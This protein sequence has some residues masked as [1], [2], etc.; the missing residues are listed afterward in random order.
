METL[1]F[2]P[3]F[4]RVLA[5]LRHWAEWFVWVGFS[6]ARAHNPTLFMWELELPC[7]VLHNFNRRGVH[8]LFLLLLGSLSRAAL[9]SWGFR[10]LTCLLPAKSLVLYQMKGMCKP[11]RSEHLW[12]LGVN[13]LWAVLF[14]DV[15]TFLHWRVRHELWL[16]SLDWRPAWHHFWNN[17]FLYRAEIGVPTSRRDSLCLEFMLCCGFSLFQLSLRDLM[18][19]RVKRSLHLAK[20]VWDVF[21]MLW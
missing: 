13:Y 15:L 3:H 20:L 12:L 21:W 7:C 18:S 17:F 2:G 11:I 19:S 10:S 5:E 8:E 14:V 6:K 4:G 1:L 9:L 16:V